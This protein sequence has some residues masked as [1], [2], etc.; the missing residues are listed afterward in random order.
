[1]YKVFPSQQTSNHCWN[2][3]NHHL[4]FSIGSGALSRSR[5]VGLPPSHLFFHQE[6]QTFNENSGGVLEEIK[7]TVDYQDFL[8]ISSEGDEASLEALSSGGN[9]YLFLTDPLS[10]AFQQ[11]SSLGTVDVELPSPQP[12]LEKTSILSAILVDIKNK[13]LS[14]TSVGLSLSLSFLGLSRISLLL[15]YA[16]SIVSYRRSNEITTFSTTLLVPSW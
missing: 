6:T 14:E 2:D 9:Y 3:H 7:K 12:A 1:M 4:P 13:L 16:D 5:K 11:I 10:S 8:L 15:S